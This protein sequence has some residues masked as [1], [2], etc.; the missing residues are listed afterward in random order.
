MGTLGHWPRIF[1]ELWALRTHC[2]E[3]LILVY[4]QMTVN[5][6]VLPFDAFLVL[7]SSWKW[8]GEQFARWSPGD[9]LG[10]FFLFC[11]DR[12]LKERGRDIYL[13][14]DHLALPW[15]GF[16]TS[17]CQPP[18]SLECKWLPKRSECRVSNRWSKN[19][20][21]ISFKLSSKVFSKLQFSIPKRPPFVRL[22]VP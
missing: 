16:K 12:K 13:H 17:L 22:L 6:L 15:E 21:L 20:Y 11:F 19:K 3:P 10:V 9:W 5:S 1:W 2:S 8:E 4:F 18:L 7:T 14:T